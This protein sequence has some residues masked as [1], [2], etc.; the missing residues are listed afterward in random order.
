M[1]RLRHTCRARR[2]PPTHL[3]DHPRWAAFRATEVAPTHG[4]TS[5][6]GTAPVTGVI[7]AGAHF[8]HWRLGF[9]QSSL[10]HI[11]RV[12][13]H[14]DLYASS[15]PPL[16]R[17]ALVPFRFP[18]QVNRATHE[19]PSESVPTAQG[20]QRSASRRTPAVR[21]S[22]RRA[23]HVPYQRP[24]MRPTWSG[25]QAHE[26]CPPR[27]RLAGWLAH[28]RWQGRHALSRRYWPLSTEP[29]KVSSSAAV[30]GGS[31]SMGEWPTPGSSSTLA[32]A[33]AR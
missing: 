15:R 26:P 23:L 5:G 24:V 27:Y 4:F 31:S 10:G 20:I 9:K 33:T 8:H 6:H 12:L 2:R 19:P 17:H 32:P 21:V 13:R 7:P 3:L 22:T 16:P 29:V 14:P 18:L 30:R 28:P 11:V 1:V 25:R